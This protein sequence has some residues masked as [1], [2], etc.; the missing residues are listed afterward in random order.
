MDDGSSLRAAGLCVHT[1][2]ERVPGLISWRSKR[3]YRRSASRIVCLVVNNNGAWPTMTRNSCQ[4][5]NAC[6]LNWICYSHSLICP[7]KKTGILCLYISVYYK[8][9]D[10]ITWMCFTVNEG[11]AW[12]FLKFLIR[13]KLKR[14]NICYNSSLSDLGI[15]GYVRDEFNMKV[16]SH[17]VRR[18]FLASR[19]GKCIRTLQRV[20]DR[21][22]TV[23]WIHHGW[24][25]THQPA[26]MRF[27]RRISFVGSQNGPQVAVR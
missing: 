17:H 18:I 8:S 24:I 15:Y 27:D 23:N 19:F 13:I 11:I 14:E 25:M 12:E 16:F 26:V 7:L 3:L 20:F 5:Y 1:Q 4:S 2:P 22:F 6:N 21:S 10:Y 9:F